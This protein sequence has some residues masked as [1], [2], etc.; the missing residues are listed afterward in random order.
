M[1][2]PDPRAAAEQ[3]WAEYDKRTA[4]RDKAWRAEAERQRKRDR[5][6][7]WFLFTM[8][9]CVA[10]LVGFFVSGGFP[11]QKAHAVCDRV[12]SELLNSRDLVEV[13]RAGILV[14]QLN[15]D[16]ARHLH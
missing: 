10:G 13:E 4:E 9:F 6:L 11:S 12:V 7:S 8:V 1:R 2:S 5:R 16:V 14:R 3:R 15:C